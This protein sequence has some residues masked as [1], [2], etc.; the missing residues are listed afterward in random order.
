MHLQN[1]LLLQTLCS[2]PEI[3]CWL[4]CPCSTVLVLASAFIQCLQAAEDVFFAMGLDVYCRIDFIVDATGDV[5]CLEANTL[6]GMT[7]LSLLPQEAAAAGISY[8]ELCEELI[9]ES[10]KTYL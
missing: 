2:A 6:P 1:K 5:Y 10:M 7:P 4:L 3:P 9:K 8:E